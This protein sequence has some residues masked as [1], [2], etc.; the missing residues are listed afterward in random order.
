MNPN[1]Y[2]VRRFT[3]LEGERL[4]G[5]PDG[6]TDIGPWTDDSGKLHKESSDTARYRAIGNSLAIPCAER[7]MKG[8]M[9]VET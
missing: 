2:A 4:Q 1:R 6:W 8:I 9:E 7:I 5:F 3:P